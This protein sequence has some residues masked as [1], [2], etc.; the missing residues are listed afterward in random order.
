VSEGK[1]QLNIAGTT[2]VTT[3][4]LPLDPWGN[5]KLHV[6]RTGPG[7]SPVEI[8]LDCTRVCQTTTARLGTAR[9]LTTQIGNDAA[10]QTFTLVADNLTAA[11]GTE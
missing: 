8:W 9:V 10:K 11:L 3:G 6:T 1:V 7:A 2:V 5:L 4:R